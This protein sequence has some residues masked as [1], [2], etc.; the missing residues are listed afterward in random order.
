MPFINRG[1]PQVPDRAKFKIRYSLISFYFQKIWCLSKLNSQFFVLIGLFFSRTRRLHDR[2]YKL[3]HIKIKR[4]CQVGDR[5]YSFHMAQLWNQCSW[6]I[7]SNLNIMSLVL[8]INIYVLMC[9]LF[10]EFKLNFLSHGGAK[11]ENFSLWKQQQSNPS[12]NY[13]SVKSYSWKNLSD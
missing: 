6:L 8:R 7:V 11:S 2:L 1:G 4:L 13:L 9:L 10:H 12:L 5:K 3:S